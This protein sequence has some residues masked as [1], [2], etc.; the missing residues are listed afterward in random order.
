MKLRKVVQPQ[1]EYSK[2]HPLSSQM[3]VAIIIPCM[4]S[5]FFNVLN[6]VTF[7]CLPRKHQKI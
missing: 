7:C 2:M 5:V 6:L 4:K 3:F 1:N